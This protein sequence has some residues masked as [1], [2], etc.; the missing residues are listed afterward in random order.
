MYEGFICIHVC[1]PCISLVPKEVR[2]VRHPPPLLLELQAIVSH[3]VG[4]WEPNLASLTKVAHAHITEPSLLLIDATSL[5]SFWNSADQSCSPSH[6]LEDPNKAV[7]GLR[8][9]L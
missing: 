2:D 6:M 3:P 7:G 9:C 4:F 5:Q 8:Y 1:I